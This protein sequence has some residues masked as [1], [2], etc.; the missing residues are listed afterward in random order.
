MRIFLSEM[1]DKE[2][3]CEQPWEIDGDDDWYREQL[4]NGDTILDDWTCESLI[5]AVNKD[6]E[7]K[8][9]VEQILTKYLKSHDV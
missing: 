9:S 6:I 1:A 5:E 3:L 7:D 8:L 2:K 4:Y